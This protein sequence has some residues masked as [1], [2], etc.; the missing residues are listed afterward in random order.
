MPCKSTKTCWF[1]SQVVLTRKGLTNKSQASGEE[2]LSLLH[3]LLSVEQE[4]GTASGSAPCPN[5]PGTDSGQPLGKPGPVPPGGRKKRS[6]LCLSEWQLQSPE[7]MALRDPEVVLGLLGST[8]FG[9]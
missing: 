6:C 8:A 1:V 9:L 4:Q 2:Q 5:P 3:P 7:P